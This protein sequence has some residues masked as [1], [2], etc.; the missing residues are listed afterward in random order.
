MKSELVRLGE[1][2][3]HYREYIESPEP[4]LYPKLSVKL[5]GKGVVL[6]SPVDGSTLR[7]KRHQ[8]AKAGQV[9]LSE[10]WGKKG[11]IGLV[12]VEGAGALCTSHF[13][14]FDIQTDKL[15]PGY[16]QLLFDANYLQE[17]LDAQAK[18]TTGYASVRPAILLDCQIP[19]PSLAEQ[20][21]LVTRVQ[22]LTQ[23]VRRILEIRDEAIEGSRILWARTAVELFSR[24]EATAPLHTLAECVA[25]MGGG[26]PSKSNPL[27]WSGTIPWVTPK[28]MKSREIWAARNH[29]S[30][31]AVAESSAKIIEPGAVLVVVRGMILA[32]TFPSAVLR[33]LSTI[34]QDMKALIPKPDVMPEYLCAFLWA[35]NDRILSMVKKSTHDTRKLETLE[36][37]SVKVPVPTMVEQRRIVH[38]LGQ[39]EEKIGSLRTLQR[40]TAVEIDTLLPSMLDRAFRGRI[41]QI[42]SGSRSPRGEAVARSG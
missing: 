26:T 14:L 7:M 31:Q 28:D 39:L 12:P 2:L 17:Q 33:V 41:V 38:Y 25:V 1:L 10:I 6:D 29:I 9:I 24:A 5:Y 23:P 34:N 3:T 22:S 16:L 35:F 19:V 18:G 27:Y 13:F 21:R 42:N 4:R 37:M 32:H 20:R 15:D 36:L 8:L 11:A 30:E 40:E